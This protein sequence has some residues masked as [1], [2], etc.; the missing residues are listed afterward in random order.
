[1]RNNSELHR[2]VLKGNAIDFSF[3]FP[4]MMKDTFL[5]YRFIQMVNAPRTQARAQSNQP[6]YCAFSPHHMQQQ[7]PQAAQTYFPNPK[8]VPQG[9]SSHK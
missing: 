2:Q 8:S 1:M 4:E 3:C 6:Y 7:F 9:K 5:L